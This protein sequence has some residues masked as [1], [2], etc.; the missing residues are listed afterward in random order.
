MGTMTVQEVLDEGGLLA[1]D[2]TIQE[3][4]LI[5]LN[6]WLRK[7]YRAWPWPFLQAKASAV[8]LPA[9][10]TSVN[11]GNANGNVTPE[12]ARIVAPIYVYDADKKRR[13]TAD[14]VQLQGGPVAY[15][16][17]ANDPLRNQGIPSRFKVRDAS[18]TTRGM[19]T[20]QPWVIPNIDLLLAFEYQYQPANVVVTDT[21]VY[22]ADRTLVQVVKAFVVEYSDGLEAAKEEWGV[23]ASMVVD[24]RNIY[25]E[26]AGTNDVHH[27]DT[28]VFK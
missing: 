11:V 25:G 24:D 20:L 3:R 18:S 27:L 28:S 8:P 19:W 17:V 14:I 22:P 10:T 9:G 1:G 7:Q 13:A 12:I 21:P 16:E 6:N 2:D 23:A 4:A 15:D 26:V 5:A